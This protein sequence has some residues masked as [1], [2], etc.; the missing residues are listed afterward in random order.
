MKME[1][2]IAEINNETGCLDLG[3]YSSLSRVTGISLH[4]GN[5]FT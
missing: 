3:L 2:F 5:G 4:V 1:S